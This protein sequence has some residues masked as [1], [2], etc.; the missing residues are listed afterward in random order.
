MRVV[1]FSLSCSLGFACAARPVEEPRERPRKQAR[2]ENEPHVAAEAAPREPA[3]I[4]RSFPAVPDAVRFVAFGGGSEPLSNQ[5][6]LSQDLGL[7][8]SML[9]GPGLTLFASGQA[10]QLSV[11]APAELA[12]RSDVRTELAKLFG[13]PG[14]VRTAYRPAGFA[15]D[16]PATSEQVLHALDRALSTG[17]DPLLVYAASHGDQ[18]AEPRDNAL[19]LWG[20]WPLRV[21]EVAELLDRNPTPRAARFV[22]T[23]CFGGGFAELAFRG[24]DHAAGPRP[25]STCGLFAAPWDD[26]A[27]GCDPNPDRRAQESYSI[28]FLSALS[29]RD[30][31]GKERLRDI[32]LDG[33]QRIGLLEAHTWARGQARSFDVP[34]TTSERY[35]RAVTRGGEKARLDPLAAP[36]EV[37]VVRT[38]G[39]ALELDDERRARAQLGEL[40]TILDDARKLVRDA[41]AAEEETYHALRIALLERFPLLEHPWEQRTQRMLDDR[42]GELLALLRESPLA[43]AHAQALR[44]LDEAMAQEDAVR[45]ERARV[46]RLVRAFETLRLSSAL[47]KQGGKRYEHYRALRSC[48]AW[49]P[50]LRRAVR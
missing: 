48:E 12:E 14:A 13:V 36:E 24:A 7:L 43:E 22:I 35:L 29:G 25:P 31:H 21:H 28:H 10:A 37:A 33:D 45:I 17:G 30:R 19:S 23:A 26:E 46:L 34:T 44:E 32:D 47:K 27:S 2:A 40:D 15:I 9:D 16:G 6:S 11:D 42:S 5:V 4:E 41:Q 8:V 20:G 18:G 50:S 49:V 39:E 38:L 1:A 3:S